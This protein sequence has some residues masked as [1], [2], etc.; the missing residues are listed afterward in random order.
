MNAKVYKAQN[1]N[2]NMYEYVIRIEVSENEIDE[3]LKKLE[4]IGINVE[5]TRKNF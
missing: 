1:Y 3:V 5:K 2:K 4:K